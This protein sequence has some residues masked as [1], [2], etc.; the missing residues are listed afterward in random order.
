MP[1]PQAAGSL[2]PTLAINPHPPNH[3]QLQGW[4]SEEQQCDEQGCWP[5]LFIIGTQKGASSSLFNVLH[6]EG[7]AC[8]TVMNS[9][10]TQAMPS[11]A[12]GMSGGAAALTA[13][14]GGLMKEAHMLDMAKP[15][16]GAPSWRSQTELYRSLYRIKDCPGCNSRMFSAANR[17]CAFCC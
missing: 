9:A 8:G 13:A 14:A 15:D 4:P 3:T 1:S 5:R 11:A 7:I 12:G 16:I 2:Q 10:V 6:E 17:G